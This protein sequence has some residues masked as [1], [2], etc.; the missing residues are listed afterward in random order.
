MNEAGSI[1]HGFARFTSTSSIS[2][3]SMLRI[4]CGLGICA[5]NSQSAKNRAFRSKS[6]DLLMQILWAFRFNPLRPTVFSRYAR[7]YPL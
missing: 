5:A 7:H 4:F 6:S 2:V 3:S 1:L